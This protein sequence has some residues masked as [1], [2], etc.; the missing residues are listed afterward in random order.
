[1]GRITEKRG[2]ALAPHSLDDR[3]DLFNRGGN[4]FL[5]PVEQ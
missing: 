5:G 2:I 4:I 3:A 1:L